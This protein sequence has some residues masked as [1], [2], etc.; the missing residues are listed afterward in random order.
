MPRCF[1]GLGSNLAGVLPSPV[2]QLEA[3]IAALSELSFSDLVKVSSV[4]QSKAW[5]PVPNADE[6]PDY[7]N[8]VCLL[9]TDLAAEALLD[10]LQRIETEQGRPQGDARYRDG[11]YA[12]RT[13][14]LDLLSYGQSQLRTTRLIVPHERLH[15]RS[16]VL[17]PLLEIA[18]DAEIPGRGSARAALDALALDQHCV[19]VGKFA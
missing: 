8:A 5:N 1:I 14:D 9:K 18:P 7:F 2:A 4:Y 13:L 12:P 3:A 16:F 6:A 19:C 15:E 11:R 10:E 17:Q